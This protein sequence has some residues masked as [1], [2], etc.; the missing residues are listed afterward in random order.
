[1]IK[2]IIFDLGGVILTR[3]LWKFRAYLT[4]TYDVSD[5]DTINV[6]IKKY[7]KPYFSGTISEIDFWDGTLKDLNII[8]DWKKLK[9]LLINYF[10]PQEGMLEL[11]DTLRKNNYKTILLSDQTNDWWPLLNKK[12]NITDHFDFTIVSSEIGITKPNLKIYKIA[13]K[14][15]Y[16]TAIESLF[17]DDLEH[18]LTP[19]SELGLK[20]VL[21]DTKKQ[22][23]KELKKLSIQFD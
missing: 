1:M 7:Y 20:T 9:G 11:V 21:F 12:Y 22:L 23:E 5:E 8:A 4:N 6:F 13:L 18:N 10:S 17:I 3:G 15:S 16:S 2:S 14:E 19:A